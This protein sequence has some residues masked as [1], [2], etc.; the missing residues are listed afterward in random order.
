MQIYEW[1]SNQ[2]SVIA[3]ILFLSSELIGEVPSIKSSSVYGLIRDLLKGEYQKAKP[4]LEE[5]GK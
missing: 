4:K 3:T 5:L 2:W 1:I